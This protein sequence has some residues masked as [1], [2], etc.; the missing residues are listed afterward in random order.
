MTVINT[1]ARCGVSSEGLVTFGEQYLRTCRNQTQKA[2][3]ST[4]WKVRSL[5][6]EGGQTQ[7]GSLGRE[8]GEVAACLDLCLHQGQ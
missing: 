7:R 8:H 5:L 3:V 6:W 4:P 2:G 1:R